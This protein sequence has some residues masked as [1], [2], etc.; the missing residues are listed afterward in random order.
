MAKDIKTQMAWVSSS[1]AKQRIAAAKAHAISEFKK[2]FPC[3][4]ISRFE[5]EVEV[6]ANHKATATVL[7][8]ERWFTNG[9]AN[10]RSQILVTRIRERFGISSRRRLS[11][12]INAVH[13]N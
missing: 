1:E 2:R 9:P 8:T 13:T 11:N 6:D 10:K 3:A 4:D 12:A 7:F 5:E